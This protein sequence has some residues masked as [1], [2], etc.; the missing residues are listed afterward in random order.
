MLQ[1]RTLGSL[2]IGSDDGP[3]GPAAAQ[4]KAL[5]LLGLL[6]PVS[7]RGLSRDKILA[8]LWAEIPADRGGHRLTQLL[9]SL[10]RDLH[11]EDLF[12]GSTDLRLN[13]AVVTCDVAE[14]LS[15]LSANQLER[16]AAIYRGPFLDGF[17]LTDAPEFE[18]WVE[19]QRRELA[20]RYA[21]VVRALAG[22]ATER[23]DC[24]GAVGWWRQL[25]QTDPL[26]AGTV[27]SCMEALAAAGDRAGA[28][29]FARTHQDRLRD[30]FDAEPDSAVVAAVVR[31]RCMPG[32]AV[33]PAA[34]PGASVAVLPFLNLSPERENEYFSDGMTEELTNA[35]AR[36]PELWVASRTSCFAFKGKDA[37]AREIAERLKVRTL[38]EGSVRKVGDRIRITVQLVNAADGYHLWSGTYDRTLAGVFSLQEEISQAIV[39]A[40][41]L[42][43]SGAVRLVKPGTAVLE[44]Y[45]LYLRGRY[46]ALKR[47]VEGLRAGIE[48][49][50]QAVE[51]DP[52]YVLA[53]AGIGE[54]W[55][56]LGFEEFGE[57]AP[58]EAMP[59][60]AAAVRRALE[61]DPRSAEGHSWR[62]VIAF[63]YDYDWAAAEAAFRRAIELRPTYS[64]AHTWYAV[65]LSAMNRPDEA[66]QR[67]SVAAELDPVAISI[68]GAMGHLYTLAGRFDEA[69]RWLRATLDLDAG[70][71]RTWVWLARAYRAARRPEESLATIQTA[72]DRFGRLPIILSSRGLALV[73][74][75]REA[76]ARGIIEE[77]EALRLQRYVSLGFIAPI[78][79]ALGQLDEA[80]RLCELMLEERAGFLAFFGVDTGWGKLHRH[81]GFRALQARLRLSPDLIPA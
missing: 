53:H 19:D 27:V 4:R 23:G 15:A 20:R 2:S 58:T 16:A 14:F 70:S 9:Y 34:A 60:A 28:L 61:L 48:Y 78:Y 79:A 64:L 59:R 5:A 80:V 36:V 81:P 41:P 43:A 11:A 54:C 74:L 26:D 45:P 13:P 33:H 76:E 39:H 21:E 77:L 46:F 24:A 67:I 32:E 3:L 31:L 12:L 29:R 75:H 37:D 72:I 71:P 1:L 22:A 18:R 40:L 17:F 57:V 51:R 68:Q 6:A 42:R 35:L 65:F 50:E 7:D 49:F 52:E 38:V 73:D 44:A 25:T 8:Y 55:A 56:L 63:L 30:E 66:I 69:I 47:T 10:R 62:G